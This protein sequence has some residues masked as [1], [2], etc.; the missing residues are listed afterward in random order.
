V[1]AGWTSTDQAAADEEGWGIFGVTDSA[2][3]AIQLRAAPER[4]RFLDDTAA[5]VH[6]WVTATAGGALALKALGFLKAEAV[7][8][9][10]FIYSF[11]EGVLP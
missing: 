1:T 3:S 5:W 11:N 8:E 7:Q 6:V 10:E 2:V 4:R 9:Y